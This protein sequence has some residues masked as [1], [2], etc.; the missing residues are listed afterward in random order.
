VSLINTGKSRTPG[1]LH[2]ESLDLSDLPEETPAVCATLPHTPP[3]D[4]ARKIIILK[5]QSLTIIS[6]IH[7][8]PKFKN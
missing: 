2:G 7:Q 8:L 4:L 1:E 5:H 3:N 6:L